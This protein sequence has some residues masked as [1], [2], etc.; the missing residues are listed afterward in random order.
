MTTVPD[1]SNTR[2]RCSSDAHRCVGNDGHPLAVEHGARRG[3]LPRRAALQNIWARR[4][5]LRRQ[6]RK[7]GSGRLQHTAGV[8]SSHINTKLCSCALCGFA[9]ALQARRQ[10]LILSGDH[11]QV[12][13][14]S[15]PPVSQGPP[16][17]PDLTSN[18]TNEDAEKELHI[19][20]T[21]PLASK[22]SVTTGP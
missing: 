8:R 19:T 22:L 3:R 14:R 4:H 9:A 15:L 17:L 11:M 18:F 16:G 10:T 6:T 21:R 12:T 20:V 1:S 2:S 5:Q 7:R 13:I